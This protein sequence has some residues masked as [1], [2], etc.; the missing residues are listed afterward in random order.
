[1]SIT[2]EQK[3]TVRGRMLADVP[4][5]YDKTAGS[6][7]WD[8]LD[9]VAAEIVRAEERGSAA[10]DGAFVMTAAGEDLDRVVWDR[11]AITRKSATY[12]VA[13]VTIEGEMH[14]SIP[15][16]LIVASDTVSFRVTEAGMIGDN[17]IAVMPVM[18]TTP[19]SVGNVGAGAIKK[20]GISYTGLWSVTNT[21]GAHSGYE[22][23]TDEALRERCL[24]AIRDPGT[25]G[26]AAHYRE[27]ALEIAGVGGA[28]VKE[29]WNGPGTVKV[30]L[31]GSD[32]LPVEQTIVDQA[33]ENIESKR[34]VGASVTVISAVRQE[35]N[36]SATVY[37]K[38]GGTVED[39][40]KDFSEKLKEYL[41]GMAF[42]SNT[43]SIAKVGAALISSAGVDDY[44]DLTINGSADN[45]ILSDDMVGVEGTV[46]LNVS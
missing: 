27:W 12:A 1:M 20:F 44:D 36:V 9:P 16:G 45:L 34:P 21:E 10:V 15:V 43:V 30:V 14:T 29:V 32:N 23:E 5:E 2:I 41:G 13:E 28:R 39:A 35:I 37:L 42:R 31:V 25:S 7:H 40:K 46:T 8:M 33:E 19:G 3:S 11:K 18:C 38:A 17:G 4:A 26:N 24:E 22:A 6:F